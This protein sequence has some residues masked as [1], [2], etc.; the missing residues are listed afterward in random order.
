MADS[1]RIEFL[2]AEAWRRRLEA[3]PA[4]LQKRLGT[5]T[6]S[7]GRAVA[8][9]TP[10]ADVA[11]VNRAVGFGLERALDASLL[12]EVNAF[13]R[14]TGVPRWLVECSPEA[15][16]SGGRQTLTDHG[17]MV[18]TP[19]VK[20]VGELE[21]ITVE[22]RA[23]AISVAEVDRDAADIF[24]DVVGDAYG[25]PELVKADL[26]S[27]L[28]HA[29]WHYYMAFDDGRP[30]AGAAMFVQGDGAWVGVAGTSP[31]ARNRGAQTALLERRL[32]DAKRLGCSWMTAE[33][34]P[35]TAELPNPSYRNMLRLGLRVAYLREKYL[36][37]HPESRIAPAS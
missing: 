10:G 22:P 11:A 13:Y 2:E 29:D 9:A 32:T 16:I 3:L 5:R 20:F 37:E 8:L 25:M 15:T 30:I 33:T 36:F 17:G 14:E 19:T 1:A 21:R 26:V 4:E 6:R 34:W 35:D 27:T 12:A 18:R 24:R 23:D 7:F 31:D 28:G